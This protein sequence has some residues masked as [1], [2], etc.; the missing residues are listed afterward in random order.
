MKSAAKW[1]PVSWD[2]IMGD[3]TG[4]VPTLVDRPLPLNEDFQ[5]LAQKNIGKSYSSTA[6]LGQILMLVEHACTQ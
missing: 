1:Q 2:D 5:C 4:K 3:S 6:A